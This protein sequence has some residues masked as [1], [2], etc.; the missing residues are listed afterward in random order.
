MQRATIAPQ[1]KGGTA[2]GAGILNLTSFRAILHFDIK[3]KFTN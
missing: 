3:A 2:E 1:F